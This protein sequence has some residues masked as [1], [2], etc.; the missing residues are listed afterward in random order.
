MAP[1]T[2]KDVTKYKERLLFTAFT[3]DSCLLF[4]QE[5]TNR[6]DKGRDLESQRKCQ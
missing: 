3:T 4:T 5:Y 1:E 2:K 6:E